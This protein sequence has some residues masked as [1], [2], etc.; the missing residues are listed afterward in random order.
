M[1]AF[2]SHECCVMVG[3]GVTVAVI[4]AYF[5]AFRV[6]FQPFDILGKLF[7]EPL[8]RSFVISLSVNGFSM[9]ETDKFSIFL[10]NSFKIFDSVFF[11][12][13][14]ISRRV[15]LCR[16][17]CFQAAQLFLRRALCD[18]FRSSFPH[19]AVFAGICGYFCSVNVNVVQIHLFLFE[20]CIR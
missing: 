10:Q 11:G 19:P 17:S 2:H 7:N 9:V 15:K 5:N 14:R 6:F 4:P 20:I 16:R 12:E 3:F 13:Y 8:F 18:F 1:V